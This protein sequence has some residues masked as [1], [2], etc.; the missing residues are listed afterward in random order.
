MGHAGAII[1]GS[2]GT[3]ESKIQALR[4]ADVAVGEMPGDVARILSELV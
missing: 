2:S 1:Q 3:A 4:N